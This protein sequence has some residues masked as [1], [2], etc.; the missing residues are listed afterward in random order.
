MKILVFEYIVGG[1]Y[2]D[3]DL[4]EHLAVQ[5]KMMLKALLEDLL[6]IEDIEIRVLLDG[7][8]NI[9]HEFALKSNKRL[10]FYKV[11]PKRDFY[12][13]LTELL[14]D[15]DFFW[16]IAPEEDMNLLKITRLAEKIGVQ[17]LNSASEAVELASDKYRTS[18]YLNIHDIRIIPAWPLSTCSGYK[19]GTWVIKP[20]DGA[21]CID[22]YRVCDAKQYQQILSRL[23]NKNKFI[24]QPYVEGMAISLSCLFHYGEAW[25]L[26]CNEQCM[27]LRQEKFVLN[28]CK[29]NIDFFCDYFPRLAQILSR[30]IPGL[31][32]YVGIDLLV[33]GRQAWILEIN[34]RLTI[35]YV[36]IKKTLHVNVAEQIL[37]LALE[38]KRPLSLHKS[39]QSIVVPVIH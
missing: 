16:P 9:Q 13:I 25:V 35:S 3:Q 23:E 20:R 31:W 39:D 26:C 29:V 37:Q 38:K 4:P 24:I 7:R 36:G 2:S 18:A 11:Q 5:G 30:V 8:V 6:D 32:G 21:G 34:P 22:T 17:V 28:G 33:S 1:G 27:M 19:P 10:S 14:P 12:Q 15:N